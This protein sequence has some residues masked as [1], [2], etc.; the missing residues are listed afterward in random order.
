MKHGVRTYYVPSRNICPRPV[1]CRQQKTA[2][3][4][5]LRVVNLQH[6]TDYSRQWIQNGLYVLHATNA[7]D[8]RRWQYT[9]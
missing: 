5:L 1:G 7:C 4:L 2:E 8:A 3:K 9:V 6:T